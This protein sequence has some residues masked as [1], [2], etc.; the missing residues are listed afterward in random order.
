MRI[1]KL[2]ALILIILISGVIV[3]Q[4]FQSSIQ[5]NYT[6]TNTTSSNL[7][8]D[9][10][11]QPIIIN[12]NNELN[13]TAD[14][15]YGNITHPYII[16][17][18]II[19]ASGLG[20]NGIH[21]QNT[22]AY[23][24]IRNCTITNVDEGYAGIK[25]EQVV[26]GMI[27][28]NTI[29]N[30][31]HG[32]RLFHSE[33]NIIESNSISNANS[34]GIYLEFAHNNTLEDNEIID[35]GYGIELSN[36]NFNRIYG[37]LIINCHY[38]GIE[39]YGAV[40][41][42]IINNSLSYCKNKGINGQYS[43]SLEIRNI[44]ISHNL[45]YTGIDIRNSNDI[46]II[47]AT[48]NFTNFHGIYLN[49]VDNVVLQNITSNNNYK[50]YGVYISG[51]ENVTLNNVNAE[52][53]KFGIMFGDVKNGT[54]INGYFKNNTKGIVLENCLSNNI[55]FCIIQNNTEGIYFYK[56]DNSLITSNL[57]AHNAQYGIDL[58]SSIFNKIT[59]NNISYNKWG[60]IYGGRFSII[61]HNVLKNNSGKGI[62]AGSNDFI[63]N[64]TIV[65]TNG[66]GI[67]V[68]GKQHVLISNNS[69]I[70]NNIGI[71]GSGE[72]ISI[73]Y[74]N[75]SYNHQYGIYLS[76]TLSGCY[77]NNI[78]SNAAPG[79]YISDGINCTVHGNTITTNKENG[80]V[81][82]GKGNVVSQNR[83]YNNTE[84]GV[85]VS[86]NDTSIYKNT[87]Y[88][89]QFE[90]IFLKG[91]CINVNITDNLIFNNEYGIR[92]DSKTDK[93]T[94]TSNYIYN[95]SV[96][97]IKLK[98][99]NY[100][101]SYNNISYNNHYGIDTGLYYGSILNNYIFGNNNSGINFGP[102]LIESNTIFNNGAYGCEGTESTL[103][104]NNIY[105]NSKSGVYLIH[106]NYGV[107]EFNEIHHNQENG[108]F[109][110]WGADIV[111][112]GNNIYKNKMAGIQ[113]SGGEMNFTGNYISENGK[114]GVNAT[115]TWVMNFLYNEITNNTGTGLLLRTYNS[116]VKYNHITNNEIGLHLQWGNNTI[117]YL[118]NFYNNTSDLQ[119]TSF[120]DL[121]NWNSTLLDYIYNDTQF[122]GYLGNYWGN[123]SGSDSDNDGI[124]ETPY[125]NLDDYPLVEKRRNY[126]VND[127]QFYNCIPISNPVTQPGENITFEVRVGQL[128]NITW[129]KDDV[130][131]KED[132]NVWNS[133]IKLTSYVGTWIIRASAKN[134]FGVQN[135]S[136]TWIVCP[137][138]PPQLNPI[139]PNPNSDGVIH[140]SWNATKDTNNYYIYRNQSFIDSIANLTPIAVVSDLN[141]TDILVKNG[142][143]YYVIVAETAFGNSSMSNC[144]SIT[145]TIQIPAPKLWAIQPSTSID[146]I[147]QLNWSPVDDATKYYVYRDI[148]NI[149]SIAT[150]IPIAIVTKTNYTDNITDNGRYFYVVVASDGWVNSTFSNCENVTV[151]I[152]LIAT[153]LYPISFNNIDGINY[154]NWDD[155]VRATHYYVYRDIT[156]ITSVDGL[157]PIA[158]AQE[159]QYFDAF[160]P[161]GIYYYVVVAS[162]GWVNSTISNCENITYSLLPVINDEFP[163]ETSWGGSNFDSLLRLALTPS[164]VIYCTGYTDNF[165]SGGRDLILLKYFSNGTMIWNTT[166]GGSG[167][168]WGEDII[169][170]SHGFIYCTGNI[171]DSLALLKF[172]PNGTL[173]WNI[174]WS[175]SG[176]KGCGIA[177]DSS[178]FIYC[179]GEIHSELVLIKFSPNGTALWNT[180]W[181]IPNND[182]SIGSKIAIDQTGNVYCV[183][184]TVNFAAGDTDLV[185][186]KFAP[187]GTQIWNITWGGDET[188]YGNDIG[189]DSQGFVYCVGRTHSFGTGGPDL[190]LLKFHPNGTLIWNTTWGGGSW[191]YGY[192]VEIVPN[193]SIYCVG[194]DS[195]KYALV[196]FSANGTLE[197]DKSWG[198]SIIQ[199][200]YDLAIDSDLVFYG[201]GERYNNSSDFALIKH[202]LKPLEPP[203][204][205]SI[206]PN[207][208]FDGIINVT[209][210]SNILATSYYVYR[211][212]SSITSLN[213]LTPIANVSKNN[214]TDILTANGIY[215]YVV[216][217]SDGW[218]NS[219]V[220]NCENV[221]VLIPLN[222]PS[223]DQ[224]T[225]NPD[226]DGI[227]Q[228]G[229][230]AVGNADRYYIYRETSYIDTV[231]GLTPI[232]V[233]T[234]SSYTDTLTA[235]GIYYYIVV[236]SDGWVNSTISN[237]EN[238]T[239]LIPLNA[240]SLDPIT[241]NP[242]NDGIVQLDWNAI[243][244]A[245]RYYIYR[246]TSYI[247]SV[248]GLTPIAVVTESSYTDTL[249]SNGVYYY[250]VVASDGWVNSTISNCEKVT[251]EIIEP[252][253]DIQGFEIF[254]M[255]IGLIMVVMIYFRKKMLLN[256]CEV[257]S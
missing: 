16:E 204:L 149:T 13:N 89:H 254:P 83:I 49:I 214:F 137:P 100:L 222:T 201:V 226:N 194:E 27:S 64:N 166:W 210:S 95:N 119:C 86:G 9:K 118:N 99:S 58:Y 32:I 44:F 212:N 55:S 245:D 30:T 225:P 220:S 125:L 18:R 184:Y 59:Y 232:A 172:Y 103:R 216:V 101:V 20:V 78:S 197:W 43:D 11:D 136:W 218:F 257:N 117:V 17:N 205:N 85:M 93:T 221:T 15:G 256:W 10:M 252:S 133:S 159:S 123:Y 109:L 52:N 188:D 168:D 178:G 183:G 165:G 3:L 200:L 102:V 116:T 23:F 29:N 35:S 230:N 253:R 25:L 77:Y 47:N 45:L 147:I 62:S 167:T 157:I 203:S 208:D 66:N 94:I 255:I 4:V 145:V 90:G 223:L 61:A 124:G 37:N 202:R 74:N 91:I 113:V 206:T 170:D 160:L 199:T 180:T 26:N 68:E 192:G 249:T 209:W 2:F 233:V 42:K 151:L 112:E 34:F 5:I 12:G 177:I 247:N 115:C 80:I 127:Q 69:L 164:K 193:G 143:Y 134:I 139:F 154:L 108:L 189:I 227:I 187:N 153:F 240:P 131:I 169:I 215:Y 158:V 231:E 106:P 175:D 96:N 114:A 213:G 242:D 63:I 239:V 142:I 46:L 39:L 84:G 229:W 92:E 105:N 140:L 81:L 228:L 121:T 19:N 241:P 235:N 179:T 244:N 243:G 152:P 56:S 122:S 195:Y 174:T 8:N 138:N 57:I 73:Y 182:D 135:K 224:I 238:V 33:K 171:Y 161:N 98:G 104:F 22:D 132:M 60:G 148:S 207:R 38:D 129:Y 110:D 79:I 72:N 219:S 163:W 97:G 217:A 246:E 7:I 196:K 6:F 82:S 162:D 54:I 251:I 237:C 185:L 65:N 76:A 50:E 234:G 191:D 88:Q 198:S 144:E 111:V 31:D 150:L 120:F 48:I 128:A 155:V 53:N 28:N 146:G 24:I 176:G 126:I 190:A 14:S 51:A 87:I 75:I 36:S 250:V 67:I 236:A 71:L 107:I 248:E 70:H 156:N 21:I 40:N 173:A 211:L 186:V 41:T 130:V 141:Y 1:R 181:S